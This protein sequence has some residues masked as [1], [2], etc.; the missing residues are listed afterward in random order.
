MCARGSLIYHMHSSTVWRA[1]AGYAHVSRRAEYALCMSARVVKTPR[2][3][4]HVFDSCS[5]STQSMRFPSDV[6]A[7][8]VA[9]SVLSCTVNRVIAVTV[10][11][12]THSS[13][14]THQY[15]VACECSGVARH[16]TR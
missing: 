4:I 8:Y 15:N 6:G 16:I 3:C 12:C 11:A 13:S 7:T 2:R 10:D 1:C 9:A 5:Y 14:S